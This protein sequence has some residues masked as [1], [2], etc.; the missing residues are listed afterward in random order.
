MSYGY[1]NSFNGTIG[2]KPEKVKLDLNNPIF[3]MYLNT[4]SLSRQRA[5]ELI[6]TAHESFNI[7]S[8]ITMWIVC[9]NVSKIE[10][11][12]DG[13]LKSR[14]TELIDLIKQINKRVEILSDSNSFEDFK[15]NVRDWRIDDLLNGDN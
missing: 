9:S 1:N 3:V 7:Y 12:Y 10:C 4:E 8:N 15:M 11:V 13:G 5:E 2:L 14:K 6:R